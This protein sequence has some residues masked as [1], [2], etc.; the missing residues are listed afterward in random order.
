MKNPSAS[1]IVLIVVF[2]SLVLMGEEARAFSW[3]CLAALSSCLAN[4]YSLSNMMRIPPACWTQMVADVM[5]ATL[6]SLNLFSRVRV[7]FAIEDVNMVWKLALCFKIAAT[8]SAMAAA[9]AASVTVNFV[10]LD[11]GGVNSMLAKVSSIVSTT[12]FF[13]TL[14]DLELRTSRIYLDGFEV[15]F[16]GFAVRAVR[17]GLGWDLGAD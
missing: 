11:K 5:S 15:D 6:L 13:L 7:L 10:T 14:S 2:D 1:M 17:P 8:S 4:L 9:I 12:G 3:D 16:D